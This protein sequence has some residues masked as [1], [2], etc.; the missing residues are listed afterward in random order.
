MSAPAKITE[1][2]GEDEIVL[3]QTAKHAGSWEDVKP[4]TATWD[5]VRRLEKQGVRM[6]TVSPA[7][8]ASIR[9]DFTISELTAYAAR[10]L[11]GGNRI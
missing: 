10:P 4:Q 1:Y 6:I 7:S 11:L 2:F 8:N 9:A 5:L 3:V